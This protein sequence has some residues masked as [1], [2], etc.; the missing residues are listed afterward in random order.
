VVKIALIASDTVRALDWIQPADNLLFWRQAY[1]AL[2]ETRLDARVQTDGD[3]APVA[4]AL[5]LLTPAQ[6]GRFLRAPAVADLLRTPREDDDC[7]A[8]LL[9]RYAMAELTALGIGGAPQDGLWTARG[10]PAEGGAEVLPG[11]DIS[12]DLESAFR[13]P[14][15]EFGL[16]ATRWHHKAELNVVRP[17]LAQAIALLSDLP[18][19]L[20]FANSF[21]EVLALRSEPGGRP[22]FHT[23][24]FSGLIGLTRF[25]NA[26]IDSVDSA[27]LAEGLLHEATHGMLYLFE[28]IT[29]PFVTD[30]T[31]NRTAVTSPWTGAT[32][33]LQSLIHACV[34]WYGTYWFRR[35]ALELELLDAATAGPR[36][37]VARRGFHRRPV[38]DVLARH[39]AV[40]HPETFE[41]LAPIE[42]RM[43]DE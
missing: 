39:K 25:T 20:A 35:R 22:A 16:G 36:M 10:V 42:A 37:E 27:L 14:D 38:S 29:A 23:S 8:A 3:V 6:R 43:C 13:F 40:L 5:R 31:A 28:E 7:S 15:D 32:I 12:L 33:R 41:F 26:Q 2:L 30:V 9:A 17:R 21:I 19:A 24:S 34:V 11:T 4:R 1:E 18:G